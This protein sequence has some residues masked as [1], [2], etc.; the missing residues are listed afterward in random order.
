M[1]SV[2]QQATAFIQRQ[3]FVRDHSG[4]HQYRGFFRIPHKSG[5]HQR[6]IEAEKINRGL[7][8]LHTVNS[9]RSRN[10]NMSLPS[11]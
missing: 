10:R 5:M 4:L 3:A 1:V 6:I 8:E 2:L 9:N 11:R 7:C